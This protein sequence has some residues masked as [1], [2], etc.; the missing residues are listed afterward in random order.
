M[1]IQYKESGLLD[2]S[3]NDGTYCSPTCLDI[4]HACQ[5]ETAL[6]HYSFENNEPLLNALATSNQLQPH[7]IFLAA[8]SGPIL[9]LG[10]THLIK[11]GIQNSYLNVV[12]YLCGLTAYPLLTPYLTYFKVP[13]KALNN[14]IAVK[15]LKMTLDENYKLDIEHLTSLLKKQNALVYIA[16]PNNPTGNLIIDKEAIALLLTQFP[17][18]MFWI[19]E[20][21]IEYVSDYANSSVASWVNNYNNLCVSRSFSFAYGL[22]SIHAGYLMANQNL[23]TAL[24]A[25]T[26]EYRIGRL[27]EKIVLAA[28]KDQQHLQNLR[29][30]NAQQ[31]SYL[32]ENIEKHDFINIYPSI[33]NFMLCEFK[34]HITAEA[35]YHELLKH[36]IKIKKFDSLLDHDYQKF[37]RITVGL[38]EENEFFIK[39]F[40]EALGKLIEKT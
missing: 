8:G 39:K 24:N 19:D 34:N 26:T 12:K 28:I 18:S 6:R 32:Q 27:L 25:A 7:N 30:F 29:K 37:F 10:I 2:L 11:Q 20:A 40:D 35:I 15:L 14:H 23:I 22:A 38:Q 31:I 9:K 5:D 13:R 17:D 16:N 36:Q 21:Y 33:A 4:L 1:S 3:L